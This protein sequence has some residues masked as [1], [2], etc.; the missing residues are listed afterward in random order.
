MFALLLVPP[1]AAVLDSSI[2]PQSPTALL[3]EDHQGEAEAPSVTTPVAAP[4]PAAIKASAGRLQEAIQDLPLEDTPLG[5][6]AV[7]APP[8]GP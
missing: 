6:A 2:P 4:A 3:D 7:D 5:M 8:S 1:V